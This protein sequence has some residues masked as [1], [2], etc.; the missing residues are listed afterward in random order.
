[1][2]RTSPGFYTGGCF[3][4][5]RCDVPKRGDAVGKGERGVLARGKVKGRVNHRFQEKDFGFVVTALAVQRCT[6]K[7]VTTSRFS[8]QLPQEFARQEG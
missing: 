5:C 8:R 7:A 1:M 3:V 4:L 6:A 2:R